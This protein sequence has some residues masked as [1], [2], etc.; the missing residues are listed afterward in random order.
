MPTDIKTV[1][2][3]NKYALQWAERIRSKRNLAHE[4]LEKPAMK[5]L[6]P[7]I[8]GKRVLCIGCG[9][10]EECQYILKKGAK[11]VMG[12]DISKKVIDIARKSFK[13]IEFKLMDMEKLDFSQ[14]SFDV[15]YSSLALHYLKDWR[16][17]FSEINRVLVPNGYFLFSTHHPVYW[18]SKKI[19]KNGFKK[20]QLGFQTSDNLNSVKFMG[21]YFSIRKIKDIW[22]NE[23]EV[24][25]YNKPFSEI[26]NEIV[27]SRFSIRCC[28]EPKA[29]DSA[30]KVDNKF[31]K[32]HNRIPIFIIFLLQKS[33][34]SDQIRNIKDR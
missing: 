30:K 1:N 6:L 3:Y 12:I 20:V 13:K 17:I 7:D 28:L 10:G 26:I 14:S 22:F 15:V 18:S 9:T 33:G 4:Y 5:K 25:Y 32:I 8:K 21:D 2:S 34:R 27:A 29:V 16:A 24:S 11:S 19:K 31:Y 23:L